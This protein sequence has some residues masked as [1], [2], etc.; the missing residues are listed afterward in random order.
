MN[1]GRLLM[2][3]VLCAAG[4]GDPGA[5]SEN[6]ARNPD[7]TD[8]GGGM[9][10]VDYPK[11]DVG[12]SLGQQ[13]ANLSFL[14]YR[15]VV[16]ERGKDPQR[17]RLSDIYAMRKDGLKLVMIAGSAQ[18][19]GPC[20]S[21]AQALGR[22]LK[23]PTFKSYLSGKGN[24]LLVIQVMLQKQDGSPADR[25]TL[26]DWITEHKIEA[27]SV[28]I[29]PLDQ[30]GQYTPANLLPRNLYIRVSDMTLLGQ[31]PGAPSDD[32]ALITKLKSYIERV[33]P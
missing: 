16:A 31:E 33:A 28:G 7:V 20:K 18:W 3:L 29:D 5:A 30:V 8:P 22:V 32:V 25:V 4:C 26:N 2:G 24:P 9:D 17:V 11:G 13:V 6:E 27:F 19:C 12:F 21:E 1:I 10:R 23:D 15:D 14:W